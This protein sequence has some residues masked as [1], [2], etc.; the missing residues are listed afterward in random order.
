MISAHHPLKLKALKPALGDGPDVLNAVVPGAVGLVPQEI[1]VAL[2]RVLLRDAS[3]VNAAVVKHNRD[4]S[5]MAKGLS[6][7]HEEVTEALGVER[8]WSLM[9]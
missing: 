5:A 7:V 6:E 9:P 3:L 8:F 1:E 2:V 4:L